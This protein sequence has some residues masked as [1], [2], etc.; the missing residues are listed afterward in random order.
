M[1]SELAH[2][3]RVV[4]HDVVSWCSFSFPLPPDQN[5]YSI[6][7]L[8]SLASDVAVHCVSLFFS[9]KRDQQLMILVY[10]FASRSLK[11]R[12]TDVI[13]CC[14]SSTINKSST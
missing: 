14:R 5:I 8:G 7:F 6:L 13:C 11:K 12:V 3:F 9:G 1:S 2:F 10:T 4:M